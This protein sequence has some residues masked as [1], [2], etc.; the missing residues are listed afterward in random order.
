MQFKDCY[1]PFS[2]SELKDKIFPS[3]PLLDYRLLFRTQQFAFCPIAIKQ[4][5]HAEIEDW[6]T[7]L[8]FIF[9]SNPNNTGA[10]GSVTQVIVAKKHFLFRNREPNFKVS[11]AQ[12]SPRTLLGTETNLGSQIGEK[13][14]RYDSKLRPRD[15]K[16]KHA[17]V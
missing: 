7:R 3:E 11:V 14:V 17:P 15:Q 12:P 2:V 5:H 8:P 1:L 16:P 10:Y 9:E 4:D 6:Q 13:T